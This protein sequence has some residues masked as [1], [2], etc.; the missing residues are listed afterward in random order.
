MLCGYR[1]AKLPFL[2]EIIKTKKTPN[3]LTAVQLFFFQD[4]YRNQI[5]FSV[6]YL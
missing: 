2:I 5:D 6:G 3:L 4:F 1:E